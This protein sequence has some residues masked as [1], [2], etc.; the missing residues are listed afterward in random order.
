[1][2]HCRAGVRPNP[3]AW[4]FTA[5]I[6]GLFTDHAGTS[7]PAAENVGPG[8]VKVRS[9]AAQVG[10]RAEGRRR[11]GHHHDPDVVGSVAPQIGIGQ[12][13]AH[14]VADGVAPPRPVQRDG[15]HTA[16]DVEAQSSIT[17]QVRGA[18]HV[19]CLS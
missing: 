6:T 8:S 4:P 7:M 2:S 14:A 3:I 10:A 18:G 17:G 5:A 11:A 12:F 15:C 13:L 16:A 19:E 1:M 9:P